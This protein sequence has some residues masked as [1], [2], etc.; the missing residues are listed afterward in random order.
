MSRFPRSLRLLFE[1]APFAPKITLEMT[2]Q[3]ITPFLWYDGTVEEAMNLY[4]S[5]FPS[6]KV[7][8]TAPG[9]GG[10]LLSATFELEGQQ[11]I[12]FNGGPGVNFS[13]AVSMYVNC[14]TQ[15]EV[16]ELWA[17]LSEGGSETGCG[18]LQDRFGL[19]WQ[20]I[21]SILPKLLGD[22]DRAKAG[23]A[24]QAM[25]EMKKIDIAALERAV[26]EE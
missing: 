11:L 25:L 2:M 14:E 1:G 8:N 10:T 18:W 12:A 4:R 9:P 26:A 15:V 22:P 17:K 6:S 5:A 13:S 20:I 3:K 24:M 23:R 7:L 16:D 19:S 21:P